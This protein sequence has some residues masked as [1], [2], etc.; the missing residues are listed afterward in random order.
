[1]FLTD[2]LNFICLDKHI[3]MT[4]VNRRGTACRWNPLGHRCVR[5]LSLETVLWNV[6]DK[7]GFVSRSWLSKLQNVYSIT[8]VIRTLVIRIANYPDL[9][10]PS[11]K[12]VKNYTKLTRPEITG[13]R[14]KYGTVLWLLEL[15]CV[16]ERF[17]RRYVLQIVT[18]A[19]QTAN[20]ACFQRKIQFSGFSAYPDGSQSQLTRKIGVLL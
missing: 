2:R 19:I 17:R 9:L 6:S 5:A 10:G 3:G 15:E 4:N 1:V 8:A 11:G 16:V 12:F 13:Y 18:S 20:V 7:A 14:L